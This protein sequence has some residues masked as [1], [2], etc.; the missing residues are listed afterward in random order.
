MKHLLRLLFEIASTIA[1]KVW[2]HKS[3]LEEFTPDSFHTNFIE[4]AVKTLD[5]QSSFVF[6]CDDIDLLD[7]TE[8]SKFDG[9]ILPFLQCLTNNERLKFVISVDDV[10]LEQIRLLLELFFDAIPEFKVRMLARDP[11]DQLAKKW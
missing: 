11:A 3:I 9:L 5:P 10:T 6:I 1:L 4:S 7:Q 2:L 8:S